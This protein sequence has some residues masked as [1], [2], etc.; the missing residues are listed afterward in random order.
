[1]AIAPWPIGTPLLDAIGNAPWQRWFSNLVV[2]VNRLCS[3]TKSGLGDPNGVVT[4]TLGDLY[5]NESGGANVSLYVKE[6][7]SGTNTGWVAK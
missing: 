4:G 6:S 5:R 2:A 3:G 1:M 7:G